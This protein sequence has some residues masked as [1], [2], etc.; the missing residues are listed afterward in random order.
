MASSST[1]LLYDH[2]TPFPCCATRSQPARSWPTP[3][4]VALTPFT[5]PYFRGFDNSLP[6]YWRY[7]E[8]ARDFD[9]TSAVPPTWADRIPSGLASLSLVRF[10]HDHTGNFDTAIDGVNTPELR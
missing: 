8:W 4:N 7:T 5:D 10:M 6:D 3:T 2:R 1:D 9:A